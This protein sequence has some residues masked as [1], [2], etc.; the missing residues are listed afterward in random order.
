M[1]YFE[2]GRFIPADR[3][4]PGHTKAIAGDTAGNLWLINDSQGLLHVR[5]GSVVEHMPWATLGLKA[6]A[7]ALLVDSAK[8]GVWIGFEGGM[9]LVKN[10]R[11]GASYAISDGGN[12][13]NDLRLDRDGA[14]WAASDR[15]LSRVKDGSVATV[16]SNNGLPC[17][18][19]HW[20][21][22]DDDQAV[23]LYMA[24]GLVRIAAMDLNAAISDPKR[25]LQ[26]TVFDGSDGVGLR[27]SSP[28][29]D[30]QVARGEDGRLWF[31]PNDGVSV[32]DPRRLSINPLPPP[33]HVEQVSANGQTYDVSSDVRLPPLIRDL[34]I[35]Y[36]ALSFVAPEKNRFRVKLEG[37][38]SDWRDVGNRR[39]ASYTNLAPGHAASG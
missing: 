29:Y 36:T 38:D 10:G 18:A 19:V 8:R 6:A 3:L 12:R 35:L 17:D 27:G 20:S 31:L 4:P 16:G 9:V 28:I 5:E 1:A 7:S 23:W 15:G 2:D 25:R 24:C 37:W 13:I 33:V 11:V 32:L 26:T 39:Q 14:L 22:E 34:E 30:P 21:M